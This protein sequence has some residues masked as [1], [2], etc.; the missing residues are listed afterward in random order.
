MNFFYFSNRQ[1]IGI[2][3]LLFLI[4][5]LF[6]AGEALPY[7]MKKDFYTDEKFMA[8][9]EAFKKSLQDIQI[10]K[11]QNPQRIVKETIVLSKFD[12]NI[13]DSI[14]FRK[15]GINAFTTARILNYR[16]KGGKFRQPHDFAKIYGIS[17]S[18]FNEL[19]PF[20][21]ITEIQKDFKTSRFSDKHTNK[22]VEEQKPLIVE[23]NSSDTTELK[24][25]K[26]IGSVFAQRIVKYREQL[27]GFANKEQLKE[28]KGFTQEKFDEVEQFIRVDAGLIKKIHVNKASVERMKAHQYIN[29]YASKAIYD[30]RREI[31]RLSSQ[32]DLT[33]LKDLPEETL[34]KVLPYLSFE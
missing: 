10:Q 12:P 30:K 16:S 18:Q 24:K 13:L 9:V 14:G 5:I 28:I 21:N 31:G 34:K 4:V 29:F 1:K 15:L 22:S 32:E 33:S 23:L 2:S 8:E 6:A 27:G 7:F 3:V 11:K 26:G 17:E 25:I 19:L 20:I